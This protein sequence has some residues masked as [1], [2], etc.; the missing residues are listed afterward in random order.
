MARSSFLF[1][2]ALFIT[3]CGDVIDIPTPDDTDPVFGTDS[4]LDGRNFSLTAGLDNYHMYPEFI[5]LGK[6]LL[7]KTT[8]KER[9]CRTDCPNSLSFQLYSNQPLDINFDIE[10]ALTAGIKPYNWNTVKDSQY[11][12][13]RQSSQG[14]FESSIFSYK[15]QKANGSQ[16]ATDAKLVVPKENM[17]ESCL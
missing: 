6:D 4:E 11:V 3:S 13:V 9:D 1:V 16:T 17:I 12:F 15:G 14:A 8:F 10:R 7:F 5:D 2:F